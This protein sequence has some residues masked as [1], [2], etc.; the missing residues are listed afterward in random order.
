MIVLKIK[1]KQTG[2]VSK[3]IDVMDLIEGQYIEFEFPD[4][5]SLPY[6]DFLFF[7]EDFE[8]KLEVE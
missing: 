5:T 7:R 6:K 1:D 8:A 3:P 2:L 4:N